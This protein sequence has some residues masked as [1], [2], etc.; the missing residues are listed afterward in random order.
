MLQCFLEREQNTH[1]KRYKVWSRDFKKG[2]PEKA[3]P[4]DP[5]HTQSPVLVTIMD[6]RKYLLMEA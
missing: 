5:S 6:V 1:R 3:P 4:G 2:S